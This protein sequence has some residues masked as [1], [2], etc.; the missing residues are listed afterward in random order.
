MVEY[1]LSP[2]A[3]TSF[4]APAL[5]TSRD[6]CAMTGDAGDDE[7]DTSADPFD[8][9]L[10]GGLLVDLPPYFL[11]ISIDGHFPSLSV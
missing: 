3:T 5:S 6:D 11:A 8:R 4:Q 10:V 9:R 7:Q 2:P 1:I